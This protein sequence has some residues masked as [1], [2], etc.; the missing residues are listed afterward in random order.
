MRFLSKG[1]EDLEYLRGATNDVADL[2]SK[3][4]LAR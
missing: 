3:S 1:N 2:S 4:R